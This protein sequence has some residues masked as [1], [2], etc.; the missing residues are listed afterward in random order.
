M[1]ARHLYAIVAAAVLVAVAPAWSKSSGGFSSGSTSKPTSS[2]TSKPASAATSAKPL[3]S[4]SPAAHASEAPAAPK[5]QPAS[6]GGFSAAPKPPTSVPAVPATPRASTYDAHVSRDMSSKIL[7]TRQSA[8][9]K[10][11]VGDRTFTP[12]QIQQRREVYYRNVSRDRYVPQPDW[13]RPSYGSFAG[14]FLGSMISNALFAHHHSD[15]PY[16][17]QWRRDAD[18]RARTDEKLRTQ[19]DDLDRQLKQLDAKGEPKDPDY[20]PKD[21]PPEVVYSDEVLTAGHGSTQETIFASV[22]GTLVTALALSI[23]GVIIF[24]LIRRR[25]AFA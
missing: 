12:Q 14:S 22:F 1:N 15:D 2:F 13:G 19:L 9:F 5:Q 24:M 21:A 23:G 6:S 18:E 17:Q 7:E 20:V 11:S 16:Y 10:A 8:A 3:F 25:K 4:N